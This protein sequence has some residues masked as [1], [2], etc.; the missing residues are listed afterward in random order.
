MGSDEFGETRLLE[1]ASTVYELARRAVPEY[2]SKFSKK[3]YTQCQHIAII[4]LK[5]REGKTYEEI[6][7]QLV[8]MPRIR[9]ALDLDEVPH[10]STICKAFE[11]LESAVWRVLHLLTLQFFDLSGITGIDSSGHERSY[12]SRHYTKREKLKIKQ[13]KCTLL[14]DVKENPVLDVHIT[15]TRKHDTKIGPKI[16]ERSADL[17]DVLL[18]DKGF[19]D[20]KYRERCRELGIRPVIKHREFTSLQKAWNARQDKKLYNQRNQNESVNSVI[21]RKYGSYVRSKIW[22][23]QFREVFVKCI[24]YNLDRAIQL[25]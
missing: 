2:S 10:P 13:L 21:K 1:F 5:V 20:R 22:Y 12:A 16:V 14:V 11:R 9:K 19:D 25:S 4:C 24:V 17:I 8:E 23:R 15:T 7:D 6:V 18:G 3:T